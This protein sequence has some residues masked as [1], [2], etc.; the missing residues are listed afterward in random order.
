MHARL[1]IAAL[2][3]TAAVC[4][5][6]SD[7]DESTAGGPTDQTGE[8]GGPV[9]TQS[10]DGDD[11]GDT[12]DTSDEGDNGG[13]EAPDVDTEP[14]DVGS[15]VQGVAVA[16]SSGGDE[17]CKPQSENGLLPDALVQG[18]PVT[19]RDADTGE[20]IGTGQVD[21]TDFVQLTGQTTELGPPPWTCSFIISATLS[22][23]PENITVQ[24]GDLEPFAATLSDGQFSIE[25]PSAEV[26]TEPEGSTGTLPPTDT[27]FATVPVT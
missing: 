15:T 17:A 6:G 22:S 23:T 4:A 12:G 26:T 11:G 24:I 14:P 1:V 7:D 9:V 25:V 5:C 18:S 19:V 2:F 10:D 21:S 16:T 8:D 20:E 27:T 3:L 13:T